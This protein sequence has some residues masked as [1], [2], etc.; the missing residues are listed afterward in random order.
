MLASMRACNQNLE[1]QASTRSRRNRHGG[2][3]HAPISFWP[4]AM[5]GLNPHAQVLVSINILSI[6]RGGA[7]HIAESL[8]HAL[9]GRALTEARRLDDMHAHDADEEGSLDACLPEGGPFDEGV[10][11][12]ECPFAPLSLST[13]FDSAMELSREL[14]PFECMLAPCRPRVADPKCLGVLA[15]T[16]CAKLCTAGEAELEVP[17]CS[18][19]RLGRSSEIEQKREETKRTDLL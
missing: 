16:R 6:L 3:G 15:A 4:M 14:S 10:P 17:S 11:L 9:A 18:D 8:A 1:P 12:D 2:I 5:H 7:Q 19:G 13:P